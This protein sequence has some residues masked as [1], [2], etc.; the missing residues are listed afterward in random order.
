MSSVSSVGSSSVAASG[1]A[2][3][4]VAASMSTAATPRDLSVALSAAVSIPPSWEWL[5]PSDANVVRALPAASAVV[6]YADRIGAADDDLR[7]AIA[8][9]VAD[10]RHLTD[11]LG[12]D[13]ADVSAT[14]DR[15]YSGEIEPASENPVVYPEVYDAVL[16]VEPLRG[17][18]GLRRR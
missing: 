4:I 7:T 5:N 1:A 13:W 12:G 2:L 6:G 17:R 10:L 3:E 16:G 8:D 11:A 14:A 9:L 15:D 18:T